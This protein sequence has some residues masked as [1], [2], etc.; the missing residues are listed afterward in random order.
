[1]SKRNKLTID[2][3]KKYVEEES[4]CTLLSTEYINDKTK[5]KFK[6]SC[7]KEF[8]KRFSHFKTSKKSV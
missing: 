6:C 4:S 5:L 7:G 2:D 1:M 8:E 3:V